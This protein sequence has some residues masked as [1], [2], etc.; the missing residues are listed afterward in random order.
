M[1]GNETIGGY[2]KKQFMGGIKIM[3]AKEMRDARDSLDKG[4]CLCQKRSSER[5]MIYFKKA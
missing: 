3:T 5:C 2:K 1:Y 4:K